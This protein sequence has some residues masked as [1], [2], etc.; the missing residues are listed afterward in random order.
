MKKLRFDFSERSFLLSKV[1]GMEGAISLTMAV[2]R[3]GERRLC[4]ETHAKPGEAG[5]RGR[6]RATN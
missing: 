4:L 1:D 3:T 5:S 6:G 2:W